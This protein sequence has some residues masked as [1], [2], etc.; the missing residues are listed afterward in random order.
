MEINDQFRSK[1]VLVTGGVGFIGSNLAIKLVELGANV[2][3][4]DSLISE[5]GGNLFNIEP[6]KDKIR[7]N[8]SDVRDK[9]AMKYLVEDQDYLFNLAGQTSHLD[10]MQNPYPDLEINARS[11]LSILETCRKYN[12]QIK[13]VFASTRQIYGKPQY[14]PVD[15]R[16]PLYPVDVNGINKMAGKFY[17]IVY[18]D[19]YGIRSVVL[20]L[21]NTYGPR[22]RVKDARQTFLGIWI[23]K[24][25]EGEKI[26]VYGDGTQIRD[27]NYLD[28]VV[29]SMFMSAVSDDVNGEI[30]NLGAQDPINLKDT[31]ELLIKINKNGIYELVPFPEDRKKIDIGDYYADYRKIR[32][33]IGWQPQ[34]LLTEG[35]RR[36]INYYYEFGKYYWEK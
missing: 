23:K 6:I 10:S 33:K 1:K 4:I 20:R 21:T 26:L 15:E 16:H 30:F 14:L 24:I 36:T 22:M 18:N 25:I 9:Y 35:L 13:I 27:F 8:I 12:Q 2:T 17:H 32:A 5:Y 34:I 19:V 29:D 7:V 28:D 31:A 3:L 11:Q